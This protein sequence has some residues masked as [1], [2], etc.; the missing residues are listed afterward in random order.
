MKPTDIKITIG[1]EA[2]NS[3]DRQYLIASLTKRGGVFYKAGFVSVIEQF[4]GKG[5]SEIIFE[6]KKSE[7]L[8]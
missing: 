6:H 8:K 5:Q 1:H 3:E 4:N 7:K 2:M